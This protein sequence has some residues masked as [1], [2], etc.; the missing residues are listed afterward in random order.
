MVTTHPRDL[1]VNIREHD[2]DRED[3]SDIFIRVLLGCAYFTINN[4]EHVHLLGSKHHGREDEDAG[5]AGLR[6]FLDAQ[7]SLPSDT[8]QIYSGMC[9]SAQRRLADGEGGP[10]SGDHDKRRDQRPHSVQ[11][12]RN[13][14]VLRRL[15]LQHVDAILIANVRA[16]AEHHRAADGLSRLRHPVQLA[17]DVDL[18]VGFLPAMLHRYRHVQHHH[19]RLLLGGNVRGSRLRPDRHRD[20]TRGESRERRATHTSA[21]RTVHSDYRAASRASVKVSICYLLYLAVQETIR[22]AITRINIL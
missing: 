8:P 3:P 7:V 18:R 13:L 19:V 15:V 10:S 2:Q 5:P 9:E 1:A 17:A 16:R 12:Q 22:D 6:I 11:V 20:N 21:V 4:D 14:H